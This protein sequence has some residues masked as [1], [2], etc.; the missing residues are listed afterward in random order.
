[1]V[2]HV[3]SGNEQKQEVWSDAKEFEAQFDAKD[4]VVWL[5][6][7]DFSGIHKQVTVANSQ[8]QEMEHHSLEQV[9]VEGD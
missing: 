2:L 4:L 3:L 6:V 7:K 5:D 9:I 8:E 1:M